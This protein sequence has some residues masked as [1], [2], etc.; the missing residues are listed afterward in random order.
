MMRFP[1]KTRLQEHGIHNSWDVCSKGGGRVYVD[2]HARGK[3]DPPGWHVIGIGF[4]TDPNAHWSDYGRKSF[5]GTMRSAAL[6]AAKSWASGNYGIVQWV[7]DPFGGW[8]DADVAERLIAG[9]KKSRQQ[10]S[11]SGGSQ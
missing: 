5:S 1:S 3:V 2:Y 8:Q 7:R 6:L 11:G 9:L 4:D 10:S